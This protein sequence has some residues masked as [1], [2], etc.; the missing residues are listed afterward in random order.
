M[1]NFHAGC[2]NRLVGKCAH[3]E[4]KTPGSFALSR[5][6]CRSTLDFFGA[7]MKNGA[8][9]KSDAVYAAV[10]IKPAD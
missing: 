7:V 6:R 4:R 10:G 2:K 3:H 9:F 8:V 1:E 5:L